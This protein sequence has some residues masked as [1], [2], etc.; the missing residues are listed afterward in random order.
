MIRNYSRPSKRA[1][2]TLIELMIV[3]LIIA[4]LV[5]LLLAGVTRVLAR[6]PIVQTRVE[7]GQLETAIQTVVSNYRLKFVPSYIKLSELCNYPQA[8][9]VGTVDYNSVQF[10]KRMFPRINLTAGNW[11]DWNR[12]TTQDADVVLQGPECLVFFLGGPGTGTPGNTY[13]GFSADPANPAN[14]VSLQP[15]AFEFQTGRLQASTV[16]PGYYVYLN[17]FGKKALP[18]LYFTS[19]Y[20]GNDYVITDCTSYGVS[21]YQDPSTLKYINPNGYQI[22][23]AGAQGVFGAGGTLWSPISGSTDPNTKDNQANFAPGLLVA[24][25]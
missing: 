20:Q 1:A 18:Y 5:S 7:I 6:G 15:P 4:I 25:Q 23:S 3:V 19:Y 14:T 10:L 11:I 22:I 17:N 9:T 8:S 13:Q 12:N 21:P 2:F 16:A 24:G